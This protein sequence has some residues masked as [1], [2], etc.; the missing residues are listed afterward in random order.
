MW[1]FFVACIAMSVP[2]GA[3][4]YKYKDGESVSYSDAPPKGKQYEP[5]KTKKPTPAQS[6]TQT[7]VSDSK[8]TAVNGGAKKEPTEQRGG[9]DPA[10]KEKA[11][12]NAKTNLASLKKGGIVYKENAKGEREYLDE[13]TIKTET[14]NAEKE[15]EVACK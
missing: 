11:C 5:I 4:I 1:I 8:A 9:G 10:T 13:T 2:A 14:V 15:V 12:E 3:E 7:T 6:S